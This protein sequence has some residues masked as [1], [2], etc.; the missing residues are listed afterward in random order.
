MSIFK[1]KT[2]SIGWTIEPSF[3]ITLHVR[4]IELLYLIKKFFDVGSDIKSGKIAYYKFRSR[5][6]L[7]II[8]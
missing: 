5:S 3:V 1:Y 6:E 7:S 8:I 2:S 4:D